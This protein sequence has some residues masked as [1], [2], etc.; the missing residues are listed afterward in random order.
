MPL[1]QTFGDVFSGFQSQTYLHLVEVY[2]L[3][4]PEIHC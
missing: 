3:H 4:F 2:V 1:F